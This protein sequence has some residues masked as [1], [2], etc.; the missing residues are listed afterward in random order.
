M[1]TV[2]ILQEV[3]LGNKKGEKSG[4]ALGTWGI[5][6]G[7]GMKTELRKAQSE[8]RKLRQEAQ[9]K[10]ISIIAS[11]YETAEVSL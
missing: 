3:Y 8:M 11:Q 2:S 7:T 9:R 6:S 5:T 4:S 1:N 10:G